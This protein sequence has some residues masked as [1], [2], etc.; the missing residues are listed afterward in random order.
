MIILILAFAFYVIAQGYNLMRLS[1]KALLQ[2][3]ICAAVMLLM[4]I[5]SLAML[6]AGLSSWPVAILL[7]SPVALAFQLWLLLQTY[8]E[9]K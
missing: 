9:G 2:S 3:R 5:I 4:L 8:A 1:G 6:L 7:P